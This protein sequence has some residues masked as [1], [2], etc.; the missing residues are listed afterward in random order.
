MKKDLY[1]DPKYYLD[2]AA[3]GLPLKSIEKYLEKNV[4]PF[5]GNTHSNSYNGQLMSKYI[6]L[7][8]NKIKEHLNVPKNKYS[9]IYT[10]S[11]VSGCITHLIHLLKPFPKKTVFIISE[12][13]HHSNHLAWL[14]CDQK[15]EI[16]NIDKETGLIDIKKLKELINKYKE[17][18]IYCSFAHVSNI[19]GVIQDIMS[20][21]DFLPS[22]KLF[23][24]CATGFPYL[25]YNNIKKID[26]YFISPHKMLGGQG[27]PGVLVIKNDIIKNKIPFNCSGGTIRVLYNNKPVY[28]SDIEVRENGGTPNIIGIIR[29]YLAIMKKESFNNVCPKDKPILLTKYIQNKFIQNNIS[30]L[31]P[32]KNEHR[33]PIFIFQIPGIHF[34]YI[35]TLL[36]DLFGIQT[37]GGISC[38]SLYASNIYD[39]P[40][41]CKKDNE[42]KK[43]ILKSGS[44]PNWYGFIR[45]SFN[46]YVHNKK[47]IDY[48]FKCLNYVLNNLDK[49]KN[50]YTFKNNIFKNIK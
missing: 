11:G 49:Y 17:Y 4:Y 30:I 43:S 5:Y 25:C 37:R 38:S 29:I 2:F 12:I 34:N 15:T 23:L 16:V 48:F 6:N 31:N 21:I 3:S 42:L 47:D 7:T 28:S 26:A 35:V 45:V 18:N 13:E 41:G 22:C 40:C 10:G 14:S 19:S 50:K 20:I 33:L 9:V 39:M 27:T 1:I 44:Y 36:S 8:S 24:D 32:I 46:E